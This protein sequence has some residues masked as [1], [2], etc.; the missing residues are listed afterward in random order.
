MKEKEES[1]MTLEIMAHQWV[2]GC[3]I[4]YGNQELV[5]GEGVE[6][7]SALFLD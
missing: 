1:R 7:E 2:R 4:R 6:H 3:A 5:L